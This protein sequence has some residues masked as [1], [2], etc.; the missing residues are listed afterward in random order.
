MSDWTWDFVLGAAEEAGL[1]VETQECA[2]ETV[3]TVFDSDGRIAKRVSRPEKSDL[4]FLVSGGE[5]I[6]MPGTPW[7]FA[8]AIAAR[9]DNFCDVLES[10]GHG[11]PLAKWDS[12]RAY[13]RNNPSV[14]LTELEQA[15]LTFK[16]AEAAYVRARNELNRLRR[17]HG[18]QDSLP[19]MGEE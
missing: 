18:V 11:A 5:S 12:P 13:Q 9:S 10:K 14:L 19:F 4:I 6:A 17:K 8:Q 2:G 1:E 15:Q 3:L 7:Q 16:H